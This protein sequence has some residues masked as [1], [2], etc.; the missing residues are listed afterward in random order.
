[1]DL[2][3]PIPIVVCRSNGGPFDD[4]SFVAGYQAGMIDAVLDLAH[5]CHLNVALVPE[6]LVMQLDLIAMSHGYV[7][8]DQVEMGVIDEFGE[9]VTFRRLMLVKISTPPETM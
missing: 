4:V 6:A 9:A 7:V 1:M 3:R 8:A 5:P 2:D